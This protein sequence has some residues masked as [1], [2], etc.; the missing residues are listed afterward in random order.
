MAQQSLVIAN[1]K[2]GFETDREPFIINNDA[3]PT[4]TNAYVWRGRLRKKRGTALL[5]RLQRQVVALAVGSTNDPG[6]LLTANIFTSL[7]LG[8]I[9]PNETIIPG[10][11]VVT[12]GAQVFVEST[13]PNGNIG[14]NAGAGPGFGT[15]NYLTGA[16]SV[17]T[18]PVL[19]TTAATVSFSYYPNLPVMGLE[20]FNTNNIGAG[21]GQIA[22]PTLVA[23][24]TV[25]SYQFNQ[26]SNI[27]YDVTFYKISGAPFTWTG[28]DYQQFWSTN[29]QGAM[30]VTNGRPGF[31][32]KLITA[33]PVVGVVSQFTIVGH[34][35]V[36]GDFVFINEVQTATG[37]NGVSGPIIR[38]DNDNFTLPT[39]LAAGAYV[40]GGIAQYMTRSIAG[41][42]DGIRWYDGDPTLGAGHGWV[43][44]SPPLSSLANTTVQYLV[45]AKIIIPFK[46]RLCFF[47]VTLSTSTPGTQVYYPNRM[48]YSQN[49]TAFYS[50]PVPDN[51]TADPQSYMANV[52]AK[53]GFIGAP[54]NQEIVT[55]SENEDVLLCGFDTKQL[56]LIFRGDDSFPFFYQTINSELGSQS[57]FSGV[58]LDIG[59]LTI[60]SYGIAMT[61]QASSQRIDV[62]IPD[63]IFE[64]SKLTNGAQRVTSVRDFRNEF[65]Y[66]SYLPTERIWR[67]PSRTLLFNYRDNTYAIFEENYTHY[68]TFRRTTNITWAQLGSLYGTWAGWNVPWN[69]GALGAQYPNII[70][71]NQQGFVML[72]DEGTTEANS[73]YISAIS[74]TTITSPNHCLEDGDF[75]QISAAIG[76]A[77]F[78]ANSPNGQ[79]YK[80]SVTDSLPNVFTILPLLTDNFPDPPQPVPAGV[81]LGGGVYK[82][83]TNIDILTKQFP[84]YWEGG[85]KTR[86]GT[87]R[88]LF[89]NT[90]EGQ[91]TMNLF[92]SQNDSYAANDPSNSKYLPY[93]NVMPT[94][95]SPANIYT[96]YGTQTWQRLSNSFIGD[97]VQIGFTLNDDQMR[98]PGIN[99]CD[100]TIH[101]IAFDL[102]PGPILV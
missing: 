88:V 46:D 8:A 67:F 58:Q 101:A 30:W 10:T 98:T 83:I 76:D 51:Q 17:Q 68:G 37:V 43:N 61:T 24:D 39:P 102:Y 5:G 52:A 69:F 47:G 33:M 23:F 22:N 4:L 73:Q 26:G 89:E 62:V 56:K 40:S 55:V 34:G 25:Y 72:K 19:V 16:L 64:I 38:L 14:N 80:I 99:D 81:Y 87:Q 13:S 59:A 66:F 49:G 2:T 65:I 9:S 45:G 18:N 75:I 35:L 84:I 63:Q 96:S 97:T 70:G 54:L 74:G 21:T 1:F 79:I 36:T 6:G 27:F 44:F 53:G 71:G 90:A 20:D 12:I 48:V 57:T 50:L 91:V 28:Q 3:F 32:Y 85:R 41:G 94:F 7:G 93:T 77:T 92:L 42:G 86:I 15:I 82:R 11:V 29:W 78:I 31:Q 95:P 60:G 100:I